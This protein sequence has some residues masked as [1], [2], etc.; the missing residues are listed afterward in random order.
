MIWEA[1]KGGPLLLC[2]N[3]DSATAGSR[4][5]CS[6]L[7]CIVCLNSSERLLHCRHAGGVLCHSKCCSVRPD[8]HLRREWS[9]RQLLLRA[10]GRRG[11]T[12]QVWIET[13]S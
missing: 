7:C 9:L 13:L 3:A 2:N 12:S 5:G 11:E 8:A 1:N 4:Q 6:P 10:M